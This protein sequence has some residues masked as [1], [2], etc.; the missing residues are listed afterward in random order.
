MWEK[1]TPSIKEF[2]YEWKRWGLKI[3]IDNYLIIFTKWFVGAKRI[4]LIYFK[5]GGEK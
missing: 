2:I 3:A 1:F 5:R 4:K